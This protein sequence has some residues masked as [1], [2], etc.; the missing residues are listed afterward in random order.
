ME[1]VKQTD[2]DNK[3]SKSAY[4]Q[5]LIV[6]TFDQF[7]T[8]EAEYSFHFDLVLTFDFELRGY[9]QKIGGEALYIDN[10]N[11][12]QENQQNNSILQIFIE[13]WSQNKDSRDLFVYRGINF[14]KALRILFLSELFDLVRLH[15]SL[16]QLTFLEFESLILV[17]HS[18]KLAEVLLE[19]KLSFSQIQ[20]PISNRS[21]SFYFDDATYMDKSLRPRGFV[22]FIFS[23]VFPHY[24]RL[25]FSIDRR[26]RIQR[27]KKAVYIHAYHP[28]EPLINAMQEI[29]GLYLVYPNFVRGNGLRKLF[30][31]S[32]IPY[33]KFKKLHDGQAIAMINN[34]NSEYNQKLVLVSGLDLTKKAFE[35]VTSKISETLPQC[36][37]D[38]DVICDYQETMNFRLFVPV[39]S[40]G[41]RQILVESV[42]NSYSIPSFL[43]LNG[44]MSSKVGDESKKSTYINCYSKGIKRDYF[45]GAKNALPLGDPRMDKYAHHSSKKFKSSVP[46][47][48]TIGIGTSGFNS[49]DLNSYAAIEFEFL[50]DILKILESRS[51]FITSVVLKTRSNNVR[52]QYEDFLLRFWNRSLNQ[53][54]I[55][56]DSNFSSFVASCELYIS[57]YSQTL[58]EAAASGVAPIY[59]KKDTESLFPPFDGSG[60]LMTAPNPEVLETY[61]EEILTKKS[62]LNSIIPGL[63]YIEEYVGQI[64]GQSVKRNLD[65]MLRICE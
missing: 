11:S 36:L 30:N 6:E 42:L 53:I 14:S 26:S 55:S 19:L 45:A 39:S 1:N 27:R 48:V 60:A 29:E 63:D 12:Q 62:S 33:R 18:S 25:K 20:V 35:L 57:T 13:N 64:D 21:K 2:Y 32:Q 3:F 40:L 31:Q 15:S 65:F 54:V 8:I 38:L 37:S 58:F 59:Y 47:T 9:I 49:I 61:L 34:A 41:V 5:I 46:G 56:K 50:Q 43:I 17:E 23:H 22:P 10:L 16:Y 44:M 24:F 4:R 28:T 52:K 7:K 51:N